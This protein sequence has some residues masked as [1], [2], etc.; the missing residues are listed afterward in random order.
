MHTISNIPVLIR[1][2][3]VSSNHCL[4]DETMKAQSYNVVSKS[5][6]FTGILEDTPLCFLSLPAFDNYDSHHYW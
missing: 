6:N 3:M 4:L 5:G 2:K 1:A